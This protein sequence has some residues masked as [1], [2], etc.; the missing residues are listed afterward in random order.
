[1][2][3]KDLDFIEKEERATGWIVKYL[4][5]PCLMIV[6]L[7]ALIL[8]PIKVYDVGGWVSMVVVIVALIL[9]RY[10]GHKLSV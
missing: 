7:M 1:M 4:L 9:G 10:T 2:V 5:V 3:K 6:V 8:I